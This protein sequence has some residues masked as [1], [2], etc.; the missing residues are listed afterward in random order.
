LRGDGHRFHKCREVILLAWV[1]G[2]NGKLHQQVVDTEDE[3]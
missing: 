1:L 3:E 2:S